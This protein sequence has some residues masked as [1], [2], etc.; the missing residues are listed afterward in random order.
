MIAH[1]I[2]WKGVNVSE[3][4]ALTSRIQALDNK[5]GFWNIWYIRFVF[6]TVIA[7][8]VLFLAQFM[9]MRR[10]DER[11]A[12]Q[13]RLT[14]LKDDQSAS[15]IAYLN[16]EAGNAR[17]RAGKLET[18]AA[19]LTAANLRLESAITPRRLSDKQRRELG[20]LTA[21]SGRIVGVKSYSSD[22]EGLILATETID[23]LEKSGMRIEDNR[24]TMLPAGSVM[25]GVSVEG[26]DAA[27]VAELRRILSLD[28]NLMAISSLAIPSRRGFSAKVS[29][30]TI[31]GNTPPSATIAIG[32]KPIK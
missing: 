32:A 12:M 10:S 25:F 3:I 19:E 7:G 26:S 2:I 17:E 23:A 28:G 8:I 27:L 13:K 31:T 18:K 1:M 6:I 4:Q 22:T 30:G 20:G 5:V 11:E 21:Y 14:K 16:A 29:V 9:Q 15:E 24:L